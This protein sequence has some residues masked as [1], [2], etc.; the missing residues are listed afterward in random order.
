[1]LQR[2]F[3]HFLVYSESCWKNYPKIRFPGSSTLSFTSFFSTFYRHHLGSW[4]F[5]NILVAT[6]M[7]I[8][9][10]SPHTTRIVYLFSKYQVFFKK[11]NQRRI[12]TD[13]R[14]MYTYIL[15]N[16]PSYG[17][18]I[19]LN[20]SALDFPRSIDRKQGRNLKYIFSLFVYSFHIYNPLFF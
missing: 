10:R 1:M 15:Y 16:T 2:L 4:I 12:M 5:V 18:N 7:G 13:F 17:N 20:F 11:K 14:N 19:T 8:P 6:K 9:G 3:L